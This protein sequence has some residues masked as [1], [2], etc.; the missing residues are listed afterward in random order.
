MAHVIEGFN[1]GRWAGL[2][3]AGLGRGIE[4][5]AEIKLNR[6]HEDQNVKRYTAVGIDPVHA[7]FIAGLPT[8]QQIPAVARYL[9]TPGALN[10]LQYEPQ[11]QYLPQAQLQHPQG[12]MQAL[13][14]ASFQ[15]QPQQP[16]FGSQSKLASLLENNYSSPIAPQFLEGLLKTPQQRQQVQQQN[17][18]LEQQQILAN[19]AQQ[20]QNMQRQPAQMQ[21]QQIA[22]QQPTPAQQPQLNNQQRLASALGAAGTAGLTPAQELARERQELAQQKRQDVIQNHIDKNNA[23]FLER[24]SKAASTARTALDKL[25]RMKE[26][27][28]TG[29]VESGI[30]SYKP[31]WLLNKE[32]QEFDTEGD[33]LALLLSE[34]QRG[35]PTGYRIKFNKENKPNIRQKREVQKRFIEDYIGQ[36][37]DILQKEQTKDKLIEENGG[38]QPANIESEINKRFAR[39]EKSGSSRSDIVSD[40]S[41]VKNLK[42]GD[43]A[44]DEDSGETLEWNGKQWVRK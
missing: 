10:Q 22:P 42:K 31:Y 33:Q 24:L 29:K 13:Q 14:Q 9:E 16:A 41:E 12:G 1:K 40:L 3:G 7:R 30:G 19:Q 15:T 18:A 37:R 36:A 5:L 11:E 39:G 20:S 4:Q 38:S 6:M 17:Q 28:E 32:S 27:L 2:L 25:E 21:G 44:V 35:T 23:P 34:G 8:D 26:L 43:R